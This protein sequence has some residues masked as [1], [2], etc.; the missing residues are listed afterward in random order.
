MKRGPV[1]VTKAS[2]RESTTSGG[3]GSSATQRR[4]GGGRAEEVA[5]ATHVPVEDVAGHPGRDLHHPDA[6]RPQRVP[7][8]TRH[9]VRAAGSSAWAAPSKVTPS[10][11]EG[12]AQALGLLARG[13]RVVR[14][15]PVVARAIG[16]RRK[17]L[18]RRSFQTTR[19]PTIVSD[20][21]ALED[22]AA[23]GRVAAPALEAGGVDLALAREVEHGDVRRRSRG[24]GAAGQAE[25]PRRVRGEERDELG[26]VDEALARPAGRGRGPPRSRGP[27]T[28]LAAWSYSTFLSS[29]RVRRVVGGDAVD[30]AVAQPGQH[31]LRGRLRAQRRVH[32][33]GGVVA[34]SPAPPRRSGTGGAA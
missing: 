20:R 7:V 29:T 2:S 16:G 23:E 12:L 21:P 14:E 3:P 34:A 31:R 27:T 9:E 25:D 1:G 28:P 5:E 24:E 17:R 30:R 22:P 13:G 15:E 33:G 19:P 6:L 11:R 26:Q 10:P 18:A 32:L 8:P 4:L